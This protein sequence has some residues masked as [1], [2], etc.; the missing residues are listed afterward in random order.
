LS[1][2]YVLRLSLLLLLLR[3]FPSILSARNVTTLIYDMSSPIRSTW[4]G[5]SRFA[6]DRAAL[7]ELAITR[8]QYQEYGSAWVA[9]KFSGG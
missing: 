9:R 5:A 7:K 4:L 8:Q 3:I 6:D 2:F 1:K